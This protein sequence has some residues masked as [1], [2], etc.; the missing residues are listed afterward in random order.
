LEIDVIQRLRARCL[1]KTC[2]STAYALLRMFER[3]F[4]QL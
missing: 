2:D 1:V 4:K 3:F